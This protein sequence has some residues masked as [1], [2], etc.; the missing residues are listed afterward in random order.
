[1]FRHNFLYRRGEER[2]PEK[3]HPS[4]QDK[5]AMEQIESTLKFDEYWTLFLR[6]TV[7]TGY[8]GFSGKPRCRGFKV[9]CDRQINKIE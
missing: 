1:M 2:R 9:E 4:I 8:S 6:F 5:Y 3:K 7:G